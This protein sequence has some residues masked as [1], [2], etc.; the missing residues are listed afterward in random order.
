ML[1]QC[2]NL[3]KIGKI[4]TSKFVGTGPLNKKKKRIYR[5]AVSQ[6]LRNT[7]LHHICIHSWKAAKFT[8]KFLWV[9]CIGFEKTELWSGITSVY[10]LFRKPREEVKY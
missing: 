8:V 2:M 6:N 9:F 5:A 1:V 3:K 4:F 10:L 7:A